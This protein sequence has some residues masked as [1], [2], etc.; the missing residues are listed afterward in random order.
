MMM[1]GSMT[2]LANER[3]ISHLSGAILDKSWGWK[4]V[5]TTL[6]IIVWAFEV[7]K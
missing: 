1:N 6:N 3:V 4:N 7:L 2:L 5:A